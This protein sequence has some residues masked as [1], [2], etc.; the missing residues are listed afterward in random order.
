MPVDRELLTAFLDLR[1]QS[2][3]SGE[4][5]WLFASPWELGRQPLSYT[6]IWESLNE[7]ANKAGIGHIS[8][9]CFRHSYRAWLDAFGV[10]ITVQQK[11]MRHSDIRTT[12]NVYGDVVTTQE[13]EALSKISALTFRK[14]HTNG[15]QGKLAN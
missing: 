14:Q 5:D 2:G 4:N 3:F 13:S 12:M 9:H 1:M 8:S 6:Y 10:P 15:T 7:A 11:L